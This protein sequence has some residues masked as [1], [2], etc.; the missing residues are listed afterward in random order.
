MTSTLQ[1]DLPVYGVQTQYTF[2]TIQQCVVFPQVTNNISITANNDTAGNIAISTVNM[3]TVT[4]TGHIG[5]PDGDNKG[6]QA[7]GYTTSSTLSWANGSGGL[8]NWSTDSASP[9][10]NMAGLDSPGGGVGAD[11]Y[12]SGVFSPGSAYNRTIE[13]ETQ[14]NLSQKTPADYNEAGTDGGC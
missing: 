11:G 10:N 14:L 9:I 3:S 1:V 2:N 6:W 7:D 5:Y 4:T 8:P 13:M 12:P